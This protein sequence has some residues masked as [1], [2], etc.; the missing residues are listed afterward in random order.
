M[1]RETLAPRFDP[2][3]FPSARRVTPNGNIEE[4]LRAVEHYHLA[5]HDLGIGQLARSMRQAGM[6]I[7]LAHTLRARVQPFL[8]YHHD[9]PYV[10]I[11][12]GIMTG[13]ITLGTQAANHARIGLTLDDI[14][15]HGTIVGPSGSGKTTVLHHLANRLL[16]SEMHL[17]VI[18]IKEDF[19]WLLR[20]PDVLLIDETT[21]WTFLTAPDFLSA[22]EHRDEIVDLLLTRFYGGAAQRAMLHEGWERAARK[23]ANFSIADWIA[24]LDEGGSP[25][26]R[27]SR[28]DAR[29][30]A[31]ARLR[32]FAQ[33]ALFAIR[34]GGIP[35]ETLLTNTFVVRA[36]GFDD[37]ARFQFDLLA[38]YAFLR[39]RS[40]RQTG[41]QL[42][43][44]V[45]ESYD[46]MA[47]E[48]DGIRATETLPRLKQ[49]GREFGIG[50]ITTTVTLNGLSDLARA[51]TH[52][53]IAL[54][55][56][57]QE[58]ARAVIR[59][60]GLNDAEATYFLR[61]M[62]RG[63]AFLRIGTWPEV[64]H[65]QI[66]PN[67]EPK[68]ATPDE[69]TAART[70]TS[71]RATSPTVA[72]TAS[73][74]DEITA[75]SREGEQSNRQPPPAPTPA[76]TASAA[77]TIAV[78]LEQPQLALNGR[79]EA[80][81]R[82]ACQR[83]IELVTEAY[84]HLGLRPTQGD[85]VK[86]RL[87]ALGLLT[88][89]QPIFCRSGRGSKAVPLRPTPA[90]YERLRLTQPKLGRG[91]GPQ[92]QY[93]LRELRDHLGATIEIHG[94]DAVLPYNAERHAHLIA[95]LQ[96]ITPAVALNTGNVLAIEVELTTKHVSENLARNTT[97]G[98]AA[99]IILA[100]PG[101]T[102]KT[103]RCVQQ[104]GLTH[105]VFI[106]DALRFLDQVRA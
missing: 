11:P 31:I 54:P 95:T 38:R 65:L 58:E 42:V 10:T 53:H 94:S 103:K 89:E 25:K 35:W 28:A 67:T 34:R 9:H 92:H 101:D 60:L 86:K 81:L 1:A 100:L 106:G 13:P 78:P 51:S 36:R 64:I 56:N 83:G 90:A 52:F 23:Q 40:R 75:A 72:T 46:L 32:R 57:N 8:E 17:G 82:H 27:F 14:N 45:D 22:A 87:I 21:P 97:N 15:L 16:D 4:I 7:G 12:D 37:V 19:G 74:T 69:I 41:L 88:Q 49:L 3:R 26:E 70:R 39:N 84:E 105:P 47:A 85:R 33:H 61:R 76:L 77:P 68:H 63:E 50:V 29:Q 71:Q 62:Q 2:Q 102:E 59:V 93:L 24:A 6:S 99:T 66:A 79:E 96:P 73:A 18:D 91:S 30:G 98:F 5:D 43:L 48:H 55:P 20:R 44:L 104:L 80:F